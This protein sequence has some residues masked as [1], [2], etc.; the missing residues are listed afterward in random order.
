MNSSYCTFRVG[1]AWLGIEVERVQEVLR[2][3]AM[4]RIPGSSSSIKGLMN[5]RG[6]IVTALDL[7]DRLS[8]AECEEGPTRMNVVVRTSEGPVSLLVHEIGDV[9][10]VDE[11]TYEPPP[12]TLHGVHKDLIKGTFKLPNGLLLVLD[13]D[14]ALE[15]A[16]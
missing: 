5:L 1:T 16:A 6:Q 4:A 7:Q 10:V 2:G 11:D 14:A 12:E 13:T 3:Q 15:V 8:V 9:L